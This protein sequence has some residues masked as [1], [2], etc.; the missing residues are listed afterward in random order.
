MT[1]DAAFMIDATLV[2]RLLAAQFPQWAALPIREAVP[3]GWDNRTFQLGTDMS[4]RLPSA[5]H[6]VLQVEKEQRWLPILA[7]QLPRPIPV[8][9]A[10]GQAGQGYPFPWSVYRWIVGE[11]A[12]PERISDLTQFARDLAQFL[13]QLQQIDARHG[14]APGP[15]NFYRGAA[16]MVYDQ[17]TRQALTELEGIID[18]GA[19]RAIWQQALQTQW[20]QAPVWLHGDVAVG[21]LLVQD[22]RLHAILDF[23]TAAVG[24]PACDTV[25]AWTLFEGESRAAFKAALPLDR[26]TWQRGR[27]WALWKSLITYNDP[28]HTALAHRVIDALLSEPA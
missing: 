26:A 9:L 20:Q 27:G 24:D 12:S 21:N 14:P 13:A 1:S 25:I 11:A 7:P 22:G 4:V 8:P 2:R 16:L 28:S 6:Y 18:T 19:A 3:Q 5:E 10:Q 17:E 23:G 15:H